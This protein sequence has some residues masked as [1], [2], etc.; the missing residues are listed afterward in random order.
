MYKGR[1]ETLT[2]A[3]SDWL[4][5]Q[6]LPVAVVGFVTKKLKEFCDKSKDSE[7]YERKIRWHT[8]TCERRIEELKELLAKERLRHDDIEKKEADVSKRYEE[9]RR[10]HQEATIIK[11][12][13]F[14]M[15]K[16]LRDQKLG[17]R[18]RWLAQELLRGA[19]EDE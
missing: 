8:D 18:M 19:H 17:K 11:E 10:I 1:Y 16:D 2:Q 5:E 14:L 6:R 4:N 9:A 7:E 12:K 3:E 13:I 15:K